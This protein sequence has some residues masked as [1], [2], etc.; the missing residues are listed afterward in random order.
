MASIVPPAKPI[1]LV[2]ALADPAGPARVAA[3]LRNRGFGWWRRMTVRPQW[4]GSGSPLGGVPVILQPFD[5]ERL[6]A[7]LRGERDPGATPG[8]RGDDDA[9][10]IAPN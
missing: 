6:V 4:F 1:A 10:R 8:F 2:L 3:A 7:L 9:L 5:L